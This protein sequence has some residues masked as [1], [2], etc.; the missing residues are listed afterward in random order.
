MFEELCNLP[1]DEQDRRLAQLAASDPELFTEVEE[2]LLGDRDPDARLDRHA[3]DFLPFDTG[4]LLGNDEPI[5]SRTMERL[6]RRGQALEHFRQEAE[7]GRGGMGAVYAI[8]DEDL[9]RKLAMKVHEAAG[10]GRTS[11]Q[12]RLQR[13]LDEARITGQLDHP[14]VV[15]VHDLGIDAEGRTYFTMKYVQGKTLREVF[16]LVRAGEEGWTRTRALGVLLRV[17]EAMSY[18]HAEGVVHRD[19]KPANIM[20]GRFGEVY[21]MDWGVAWLRSRRDARDVRPRKPAEES[22]T[23]EIQIDSPVVTM[24][25]AVVGTPYYMSPEQSRGG[26][27][28]ER[29]DVY[30]VVAMLY[31]LV[32]GTPP[33]GVDSAS[34]TP[35]EVLE[36]VIDGPPQ[37]ARGDAPIPAELEAVCDKAMARAAEQRYPSMAELAEDLRA[38]L[39]GR[40]VSAHRTGAIA[41][42]R[43]W[44][45]RN[46]ALAFSIAASIVGMAAG[47]VASLILADAAAS[48]QAAAEMSAAEA[49]E[50][51]S[52]A[53]QLSTTTMLDFLREQARDLWPAHP[54]QLSDYDRWLGE[55]E[56]AGTYYPQAVA[57][58]EQLRASA[59][60]VANEERE[61][62]THPGYPELRRLRAEL[63]ALRASMAVARGEGEPETFE[64][65]ESTE[66]DDPRE[67]N[68]LAWNLVRPDRVIH[69]REA[70][71]LA[72]ARLALSLVAD[73]ALLAM[74]RDTLAW[75]LLANG[76]LDEAAVESEL[77]IE[78]APPAERARSEEQHAELLAAIDGVLGGSA[79]ARLEERVESLEAEVSRRRSWSFANPDDQWSHDRLTHFVETFEAL[80]DTEHGLVRGVSSTD[81]WGVERRRDWA[82]RV[83]DLT[84]SGPSAETAWRRAIASIASTEECP[85]YDSLR[86]EPQIGLLPLGRDDR[87]GLWEF[88]HLQ[89][90]EPPAKGADGR[91]VVEPATGVVLVLIPG[92]TFWMGAQ[93]AHPDRA[94]YDPAARQSEGPVHRVEISP[95]FLSKYEMTQAQWE[96]VRAST[97][98]FYG[99]GGGIE[100]TGAHP[101]ERVSW[102]ACDETMRW[103][104]LDLPTEAQWEYAARAGTDTPWWTGEHRETLEGNANL[105]DRSARDRGARWSE[106]DDWPELY[107]GF[108]VHAPVDALGPNPWGLHGVAGNVFEWCR[109]QYAP[110]AYNFSAELDPCNEPHGDTNRVSRGGSLNSTSASLRSAFR[111]NDAPSSAS[112]TVGLR[113]ARALDLR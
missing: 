109:D 26:F 65:D 57:E 35:Y 47:L 60:P 68:D 95:Y 108:P 102:I 93:S 48:G 14:G 54:E 4:L 32:S 71:G 2:I 24:D 101:V 110:D 56:I 17:C 31:T 64:V 15:P 99:P 6:S 85:A 59:L 1:L 34:K 7:V 45:A 25:G 36:R 3:E 86:I 27:V 63:G 80:S 11:T 53:E 23:T 5:S 105:A 9:E 67:L 42:L 13:F 87:S 28:D 103:L 104:G 16:R 20:V 46:R 58:L 79:E 83:D 76:L 43:K 30:A 112:S 70:E 61:R 50:E 38:Y 77:A 52:R 44:T 21:V 69:G 39:E 98:S 97:P 12:R 74:V 51:R 113:P 94:N 90:G 111:Q 78:A 84:L 41:E 96:R 88:V 106:I 55:S 92:G 18:A 82:R 37:P 73:E 10:T 75:A 8:W 81:G 91:W 89:T 40:V 22:T 49:R 100:I 72:L 29:S 62:R 66:T 33:Y 19:L 107:D